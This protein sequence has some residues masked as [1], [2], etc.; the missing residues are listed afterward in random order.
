MFI[1]FWDFQASLTK[2]L[3]LFV[4]IFK[5][6][7]QKQKINLNIFEAQVICS[8]TNVLILQMNKITA[9]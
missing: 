6:K 5:L 3:N 2:K 7:T 4:Q 8:L 1:S 9:D